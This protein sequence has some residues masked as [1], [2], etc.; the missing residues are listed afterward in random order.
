MYNHFKKVFEKKVEKFGKEKME[1]ELNILE[2]ANTNIRVSHLLGFQNY[3]IC[4]GLKK[5]IE[6]VLNP[7]RFCK[8]VCRKIIVICI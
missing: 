2:H 1:K 5:I 3:K 4:L 8:W 6:N 7:I